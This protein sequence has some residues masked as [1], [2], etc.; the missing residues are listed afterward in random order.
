MDR[1]IVLSRMKRNPFFLIGFLL[2]FLVIVTAIV[3][4]FLVTHDPLA[5]DLYSKLLPPGTDGHLLGTDQLGRDIFSRIIVGARMSLIISFFVSMISVVVGGLLGLVS[6]YCGGAIDAVIMRLCD[7]ILALPLIVVTIA[8]VAVLGNTTPNL[9]M[10]LSILGWVE[11]CKLTR[12]N[13]MVVKNMEFVSA[14]KILGGKRLRILLKEIFPNV[15]TTL[16]IQTSLK[17]GNVIL[18]EASL[19]YLGQG[20]MQPTPSW[21]NMIADGRNYLA[22]YPWVC[23]VPGVALMIS[24][25]GFNFLGDGLR[26]VLDPKRT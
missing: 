25:L 24:I 8:L 19:S 17:F 10:I 14:I 7:I 5:N 6:G 26:D 3:G 12:N 16:I 20:I 15:T 1:K 11:F 2:T 18:T 23:L 21:G 9:I 4:P 13:V 22:A